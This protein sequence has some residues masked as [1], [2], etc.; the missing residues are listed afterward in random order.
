MY[1]G[2]YRTICIAMMIGLLLAGLYPD[3]IAP[4]FFVCNSERGSEFSL[5]SARKDFNDSGLCTPDM[6]GECMELQSARQSP[7]LNLFCEG[8]AA[9]AQG[10]FLQYSE[11]I[12]TFCRTLDALVMDYM[13]QSDGKKRIRMTFSYDKKTE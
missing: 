12:Y 10:K 13:H 9:P 4:D 8:P 6:L 5:D 1:T 3:T 2:K 11:T 7:Y